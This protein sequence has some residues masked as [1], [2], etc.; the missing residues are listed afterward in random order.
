MPTVKDSLRN[1]EKV[2]FTCL[3]RAFSMVP[4][5]G[6]MRPPTTFTS[7]ILRPTVQY[8]PSLHLGPC[9]H[10]TRIETHLMHSTISMVMTYE[11]WGFNF[12]TPGWFCANLFLLL[13]FYVFWTLFLI[14][15]AYLFR[16]NFVL[17]FPTSTSLLQR[18]EFPV[19]SFQLWKRHLP[20]KN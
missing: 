11:P 7:C 1:V 8:S 13:G 17:V 12:N 15:E 4:Q 3:D 19:F 5:M 10:C 20:G 2:F 14:E 16:R 18:W 9:I 6:R